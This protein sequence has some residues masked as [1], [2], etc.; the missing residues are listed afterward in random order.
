M[1]NFENLLNKSFR[2][3]SYRPRSEKEVRDYLVKKKSD[4]ITVRKI[5]DRLKKNN[6]VND[7]EFTKWWIE[8]RT[9]KGIKFIQFELKQKGIGKDIIEKVLESSSLESKTDFE[10]ALMLAEKKITRYKNLDRQKVYEKMGRFLASRGFDWETV[11]KVIDRV[12]TK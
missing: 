2:F 3:L 11:K 10:K 4:E 5:I 6:F 12:L 1:D 9:Q 7:E 8:H